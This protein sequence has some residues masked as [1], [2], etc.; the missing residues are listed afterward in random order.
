M[1]EVTGLHHEALLQPR[2]AQAL[3]DAALVSREAGRVTVFQL[4]HSQDKEWLVDDSSKNRLLL[5]PMGAFLCFR[6]RL[7]LHLR[8]WFVR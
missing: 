7:L 2:R 1:H 6:R 8:A 4:R 3:V 5:R